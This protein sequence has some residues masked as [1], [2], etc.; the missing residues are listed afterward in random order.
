MENPHTPT[1]LAELSTLVHNIA[2]WLFLLLA[3]AYLVE[4]VRGVPNGRARYVWPGIG[5]VIGFGLTAFV[6]VHQTTYHAVSPFAD[7]LQLQHQVIGL[8]AGSGALMEVIA[9]RTKS[10]G[11]VWR[12]GWPL[13]LVGVGVAFLV[14]EQGTAEAL[15]VHWALAATLILAGL[16]LFAVVLA[17]EQN[18]SLVLFSTFLLIG[19]ALQLVVFEEKPGAH[20]AHGAS[21]QPAPAAQNGEMHGG[22]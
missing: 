17:G 13:S 14:H 21:E 22:H 7:P 20:G 9:R 15:L 3:L 18:R 2:G 5:A 11:K 8:L 19:A 6:F 1:E 4:T 12:S 16:G 10:D